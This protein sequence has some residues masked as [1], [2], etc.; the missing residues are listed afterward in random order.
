MGTSQVYWCQKWFC[1]SVCVP[2]PSVPARAS[3]TRSH[4]FLI[5]PASF[6]CADTVSHH[7]LICHSQQRAKN[8]ELRLEGAMKMNLGVTLVCSKTTF[9]VCFK[10]EW[11][12][13]ILHTC[14]HFW[15][16]RTVSISA[17][18][19]MYSSLVCFQAVSYWNFSTD[20]KGLSF[21]ITQ[22]VVRT[23]M[24]GEGSHRKGMF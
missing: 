12:D 21:F 17:L 18:S 3:Q 19:C 2:S 6:I 23:V 10:T 1:P 9:K 5:G 16:A 14:S 13:G 8:V 15:V 22:A 24:D 20:Y 4:T 7:T 11:M